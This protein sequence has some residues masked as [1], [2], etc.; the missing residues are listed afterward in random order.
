MKWIS[1]QTKE[2]KLKKSRQV[3]TQGDNQVMVSNDWR[4]KWEWI[5]RTGVNKLMDVVREWDDLNQ[6]FGGGEGIDDDKI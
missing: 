5:V 2:A 1:R 3:E 4:S 6:D